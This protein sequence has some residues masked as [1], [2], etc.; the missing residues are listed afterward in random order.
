MHSGIQG[1]RLTRRTALGA[2]SVPLLAL[3]APA[4]GSSA[5][6]ASPA[7]DHR[8]AQGFVYVN[9][10]TAGT[11]T[12][13]GFARWADGALTPLAGSPF[14]IG[15]SGT[16]HSVASQGA[17]QLAFD[18]RYLLAANA[19]SNSVS[20][21]RILPDGA[22]RPVEG[23]P[24]PSGGNEPVSIAVHD[25]L[26]YVGNTGA[27]GSNY[28]GFTLNRAGW[29]RPLA[30]STVPLPDA[31]VVGDV[32]ISGNGRHLAGTRVATSLIDSFAINAAGRLIV[33][34]GSPFAAQ[35]AGPFGSA[36]RPTRANQLFVSNAH[37]GA[38][39]G[40]VSAFQVARD[41][42]L[43]SIG[44]SPFAD[45]QTAPC[46]VAVSP[47]GAYL[48]AANTGSDSISSY[49]VDAAGDLRL[50]GATPLKGGPG[51]G[52]VDLGT[53]AGGRHL[54]VVDTNRALVSE[55]RVDGGTLTELPSSPIAL[56]AGATPFGLAIT[57]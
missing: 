8:Q 45:Q 3:A 14:A 10:N 28:T 53:D 48:F 57:G 27:G 19:G 31:S 37:G 12:V 2:L 7:D 41:G 43:T 54:Y 23:S 20:V 33:A 15:G 34:P 11:N 21:L 51:L 42:A 24:F 26:V 9:D 55:L 25:E 56:P 17:L 13:A 40:T 6:F 36:F 18:G 22:L 52:T 47:N 32:L 50:V 46:W 35:G 29:L 49:A 16:G 4:L 1:V 5:V 39:N 38:G 30:D 44:A